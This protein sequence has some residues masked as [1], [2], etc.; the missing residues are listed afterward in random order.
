MSETCK[1]FVEDNFKTHQV[2]H[3][4]IFFSETIFSLGLF[5]VMGLLGYGFIQLILMWK[6]RSYT[7]NQPDT[8][9]NAEAQRFIYQ[10]EQPAIVDVAPMLIDKQTLARPETRTTSTQIPTGTIPK[11]KYEKKTQRAQIFTGKL[12]DVFL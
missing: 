4:L 6:K 3:I 1:F 5:I 9:E 12:G 11:V 8:Q 2:K 7:V 10:P